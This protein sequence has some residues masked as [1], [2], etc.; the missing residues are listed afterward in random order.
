MTKTRSQVKREA[1]IVAAKAA[2]KAHGVQATTMD[3][4][5]ELAQVSKRTVY[6]HFA[7]KEDLVMY[8]VTD[9]WQQSLTKIDV[10]YC[11]S[12]SLGAQLRQLISQ[13]IDLITSQEYIDLSR[14]A[15]G[16]LFYN[17]EVL[18]QEI[19]KISEHETALQRW[20]H[21]AVS[22]NALDISDINFAYEQLHNMIKGSCFWPLI[23]QM[24]T[25]LS[26]AEKTQI[27]EETIKTFLARYAAV[28][29]A[30]NA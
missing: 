10:S 1:I 3:K 19:A 30:V 18:Q 28:Q 2:F 11:G 14:V 22:D 5:A 13:E 20:L 8:L 9:L 24:K 17:P 7:T 27:V 4:L 26:P 6:N 23:F 29:N 12:Q 21:D 15:I 25:E 16:H